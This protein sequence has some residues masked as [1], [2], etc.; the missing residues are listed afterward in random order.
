MLGHY[1]MF[2]RNCA[3]ALAVYSEAF[4]AQIIEKQT[5]GDMPANP[6]FPVSE[7]NKAQILHARL[8]IGDAELQCDDATERSVTGDNMYVSFT[9]CDETVVRNAWDLLKDGGEIYMDLAPSFFA[10]AHGSLRD[11][12]GVNWMF[13]VLKEGQE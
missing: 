7:A 11:K 1:L 3:E 2:N 9:S 12:F 5:Y 6:A 8:R 13:T 10:V 4:G